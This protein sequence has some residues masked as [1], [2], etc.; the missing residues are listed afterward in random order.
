[1]LPGLSSS[2]QNTAVLQVISKWAMLDLNQRPPPCKGGLILSQV[3]TVVQKYLQISTFTRA[4]HRGCSL[5]FAWV[6]VKLVSTG[7]GALP[8]LSHVCTICHPFRG[9]RPYSKLGPVD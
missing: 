5:L 2:P 4:G 9:A 7:V 8:G 3:F 1:M 6:G